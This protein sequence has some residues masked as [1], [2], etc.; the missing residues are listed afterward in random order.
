MAKKNKNKS[1]KGHN[2][3][4]S[5]LLIAAGLFFAGLPLTVNYMYSE[6]KVLMV[7]GIVMLILGGILFSKSFFK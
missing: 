2:K 1:G 7:A 4:A 5:I 6:L 3:V